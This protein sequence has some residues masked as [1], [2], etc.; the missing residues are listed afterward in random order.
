M[1]VAEIA[2]LLTLDELIGELELL[3]EFALLFWTE[4]A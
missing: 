4:L 1:R 2:E 3:E